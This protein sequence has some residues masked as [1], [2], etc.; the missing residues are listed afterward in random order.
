MQDIKELSLKELEDRLLFWGSPKY[1]ARLIW[2][3]IYQK[4]AYDFSQMSNLPAPLRKILTDEFSILGIK[5][6]DLQVSSDRT[7]KFLF[8]L[9]DKN[10]MEAVN[11]PMRR[12]VRFHAVTGCISSQAGCKFGCSFCAS[13]LGGFKRNLTSG[14][15]LDEVLYLK[16]NLKAGQLTHIV[17]MGTGEPMDNYEYVL[18]AIRIINSPFAF[19]IGARRITISTCGIIPS[20]DK[21]ALEDLQVELSISLHAATDKVR[22]QL[23]PVNNK[24]PLAA[25]IKCCQEYIAKT[26]R[27][28]TFE[29]ILIKG[30]NSDEADAQNLVKLLKDLRLA[31]VNLIPANSVPESKIIPLDSAQTIYFKDYLFKAGLNVTL[32]REHGQDIDAACGQ[33]RLKYA[34]N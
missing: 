7:T 15:I 14:E 2:N 33:L 3:W 29:Y 25:L 4:G 8:E 30:V 12:L 16:N 24:Y 1:Y 6:A 11:I 9:A 23:M 20:I 17:F 34:K 28:I 5:L 22:S 31:K 13:S 26:N 18:K 19:N 10:L 27:Q 32:R 21:L